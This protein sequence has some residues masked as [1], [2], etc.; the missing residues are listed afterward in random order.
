MSLLLSYT[1]IETI[2]PI[3]VFIY[4]SQAPFLNA[5]TSLTTILPYIQFHLVRCLYCDSVPLDFLMVYVCGLRLCLYFVDD[6]TR[7]AVIVC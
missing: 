1:Y 6:V 2:K 5:N 4:L 7:C 3:F